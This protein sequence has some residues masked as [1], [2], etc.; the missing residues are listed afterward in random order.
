MGIL[1][2]IWLIFGAV[3]GIVN[4]GVAGGADC[5]A[6]NHGKIAFLAAAITFIVTVLSLIATIVILGK[7]GGLGSSGLN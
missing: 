7:Y 2:A 4:F 5:K 6:T 3:L 1:F